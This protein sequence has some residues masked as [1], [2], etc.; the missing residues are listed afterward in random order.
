MLPVAR[1]ERETS[2]G[3]LIKRLRLSPKAS[4][5]HRIG[6]NIGDT[7]FCNGIQILSKHGYSLYS[8]ISNFVEIRF[9]YYQNTAN[10]EQATASWCPRTFNST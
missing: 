7:S 9:S 2:A 3:K 1:Q 4:P 5:T 6:I 8:M 10:V